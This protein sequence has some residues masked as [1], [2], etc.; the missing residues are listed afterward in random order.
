DRERATG[1]MH[2]DATVVRATRVVWLDATGLAIAHAELAGKPARVIAGGDD[3]IGLD[4]GELAPGPLA[5]DVAFDAPIDHSR[6][7]GI[8]VE[9]EHGVPYV[10]TFFEPI[11]ARRAFPCFDEPAYKVPWQLVFHVRASDVALG[12]AP[13]VGETPEAGDMKRVELAESKP[14]PSYLVAFVVG[15]FE[16]I[17]DGTAGRATTPIRFVIPQGRA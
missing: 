13:I 7:R 1:V 17:D 11:D 14:L 9:H 6:S 10:Y 15:P 5:I 8:Y 16:V 4:A 3:F 2:V 12:N